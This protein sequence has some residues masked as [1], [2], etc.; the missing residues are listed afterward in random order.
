EQ[1]YRLFGDKIQRGEDGRL[2]VG[3]EYKQQSLKEYIEAIGED[4]NNAHHF[5]PKGGSG[6]G[7]SVGT[8]GGKGVNKNPWAK[9]SFNLTEQGRIFKQNPDLAHR[10][11][12]E[13]GVKAK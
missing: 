9:D 1:F 12:A 11:M 4:E 8:G 7:A 2:F 5:K 3:D 10:L 13:A 6:V